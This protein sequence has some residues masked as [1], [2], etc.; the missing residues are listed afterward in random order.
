[1]AVEPVDTYPELDEAV[2]RAR[3]LAAELGELRPLAPGPYRSP[4]GREVAEAV[5]GLLR[6]GTYAAA[7]ARVVADDP[8]L[9]G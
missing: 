4:V 8:E 3:R 6:D 9:A 2:A 5:M 7:V 1:M